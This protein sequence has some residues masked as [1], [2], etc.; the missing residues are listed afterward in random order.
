MNYFLLKF[1]ATV[2]GI[3]KISAAEFGGPLPAGQSSGKA[4]TLPNPLGL[5]NISQIINNIAYY[6]SVY[7]APPIV[8]IMILFAAFQILTAGENPEKIKTAKQIILWACVGYA[9]ILISWGIASIV[10]ELLGGY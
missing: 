4:F 2:F 10:Q 1:C 5:E 9:I 7:I 8:T 6:L 3:N